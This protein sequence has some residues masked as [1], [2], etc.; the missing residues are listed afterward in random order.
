MFLG[1]GYC[2]AAEKWQLGFQDPATPIMEGIINL[3]DDVMFFLVGTFALVA[4]FFVGLVT[5]CLQSQRTG[6]FY[7]PPIVHHSALEF[8]WTSVPALILVAIAV[9][10]FALIY[11]M[12][13]LISAEFSLK[14][15]GHQWYWSYEYG[16][17]AENPAEPFSST[18]RSVAL[19]AYMVPEEDLVKGAFRL[20][21]TDRR[22]YLPVN[23]HIRVLV[24]S[25]DVIHS[26]A[27][28]SLGIKVDACPG[29]LNQ[30]STYI[31]RTG[32]FYGQCSE[33]CGVNHAFMPIVVEVL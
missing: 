5:E 27:V 16:D 3:H 21:E 23:T 7:Y 19:D 32:V 20:L 2:D 15:I 18:N 6:K 10:S 1:F 12:D 26:W 28:P 9:P 4:T 25:A 22:V 17:L 14:V 13:D 24:T 30:I 29:R 31:T 11:S 8:I 33:I